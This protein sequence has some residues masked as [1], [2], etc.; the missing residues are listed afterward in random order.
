[1]KKEYT[2]E[3][4]YEWMDSLAVTDGF[5]W[6]FTSGGMILITEY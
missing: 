5:V 3:S 4:R 2:M 6:V 1:M